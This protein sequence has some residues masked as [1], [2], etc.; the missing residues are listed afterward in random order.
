VLA[1]A[2]D[3]APAPVL[4]LVRE[5][6]VWEQVSALEPATLV[7]ALATVSMVPVPDSVMSS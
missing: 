1:Q 3:M 4:E 7:W 2:P 6:V 5:P